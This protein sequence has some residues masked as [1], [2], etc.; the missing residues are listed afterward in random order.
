MLLEGRR[1]HFNLAS[2]ATDA[3]IDG[4]VTNGPVSYRVSLL[5]SIRKITL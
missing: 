4:L 1:T 5:L 3:G 2:I